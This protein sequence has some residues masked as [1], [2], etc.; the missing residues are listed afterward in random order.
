MLLLEMAW[1]NLL[2][3]RRRT[4]S[5]LAAISGGVGMI[6]LTNAIT[7]GISANTANTVINQ[8]DG[9]LRIEHRDYRKYFLS[10]QEK[11][12]IGD[13]RALAGE[14]LKVPHVRSIMPRVVTGGLMGKDAKSTTFFGF[15]SDLGSLATVLPDYGKNL[16][17]GELL[18]RDDPDGVLVGRALARSLGLEIGDELVLLSKTVHGEQS[19]ALVH[20][21]GVVTFPADEVLERSLMLTSLG[22]M[23]KD[24]LLDLGEGATQLVVRLDDTQ[25]VSQAEA[26]LNRLF[27]SRGLPWRVV[28][29]YD[30]VAFSRMVGVFNGIGSVIAI[31]LVVMVG[32]I[33]S[34][35]LLMAFFE[36]IREIG[37]LRAIGMRRGQVV[38]LLFME[39][40]I[41]GAC[42]SLAGLALGVALTLAAAHV[43]IPL[44]G[45]V[46][47]EVRPVLNAASLAVSMAA[48]IVCIVIA[49]VIP[50]R[51]A[52]RMNV[53]ESFNYQ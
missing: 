6:V 16:V 29:W 39:S 9:H 49:A 45:I 23:V 20:V 15:A 46:N 7:G 24:N 4:F 53:I 26:A 41:V 25:N 44:G 38:R 31:I 42:G 18:S 19:N 40:A 36:R 17:T 33:T 51:A 37:T 50:I 14:V 43:G 48:P 21:R 28:P 32:V 30:N 47:Q 11:I 27:E 10:D 12:L 5:T 22:K 35:A 13:Y 2:R 1:N 3:N 52:A 34:N 8:I